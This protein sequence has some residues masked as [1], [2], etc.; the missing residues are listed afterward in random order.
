MKLVMTLVLL[1]NIGFNWAQIVINEVMVDPIGSDTGNEWIELYNP[2][3]QAV[4]V[5][6]WKIKTAGTSFTLDY[7]I[8]QFTMLP[9]SFLLIGE[10]HISNANLITDLNFQNGGD[11]S[12]GIRLESPDESYYDTLIYDS[13]NI[14]NLPDDI[15]NPAI[16]FVDNLVSGYSIARKNDG[17]DT[18]SVSDWIIA[19]IGTPGYS[20]SDF[21]DFSITDIYINNSGSGIEIHTIIHNLSTIPINTIS[22][23]IEFLI[24]NVCYDLQPLLPFDS[25][26]NSHLYTNFQNLSTGIHK[27]QVNVLA[28]EDVNINNNTQI[29]YFLIGEF[30]VYLNE[31][32]HSPNTGFPEWVE[33]Y[34]S[35]DSLV[36]LQNVYIK[37]DTGTKAFFNMDIGPHE[38]KIICSNPSALIMNYPFL[39]EELII[40]TSG[41]CSLNNNGDSVTFCLFENFPVD[42]LSYSTNSTPKGISLERF[43]IDNNDCWLPS[44]NINGASPGQ[45]NQSTTQDSQIVIQSWT[46]ILKDNQLAHQIKLINNFENTQV[47][48][49]LMEKI[50]NE[51]WITLD[52]YD[53]NFQDELIIDI[54]SPL[55][56]NTYTFFYLEVEYLSHDETYLVQQKNSFINHALPIVVNEIMYNPL[57]NEPEWIELKLNKFYE[58][59]FVYHVLIGNDSILINVTD[60]EFLIITASKADSIWLSTHYDLHNNSLFYGFINLSNSGE[61]IIIKDG[62]NQ[63]IEAFTYNPNWSKIKGTSIERISSLSSANNDLNWS[64]SLTNH[65]IG[66]ENSVYY[67]QQ[68]SEQRF[69]I[70]PKIFSPYRNESSSIS[71]YFPGSSIDLKI[72]IFNL[73]GQLIK[74][75]SN[76]S[77]VDGHYICTWDGKD[78]LN[79]NMIPGIYPVYIEARDQSGKTFKKNDKITLGY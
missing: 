7:T 29:K 6:G 69:S 49:T 62:Y 31:V 4:N 1:L 78:D 25:D 16:N 9:H 73:K 56:E 43:F 28:I 70:I 22:I 32:M 18:N 55:H 44:S 24:D 34:N 58:E 21:V 30:P 3:E 67:E 14:N 48:I 57:V 66:S 68:T 40:Q 15:H 53:T 54:H 2:L 41:W 60:K 33:F 50:E 59:N 23:C 13:P 65:T 71:C 47:S 36:S 51:E 42:S 17:D 79:H 38:Y 64:Q 27:L 26:N 12:D 35:S 61:V 11:A 46:I 74:E 75:L 52:Q 63:I 39:Q 76:P 20:N 37:D 8:P 77:Y 10:E 19:E 45:V 72:K 5:T